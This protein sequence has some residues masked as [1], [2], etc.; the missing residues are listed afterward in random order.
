MK[1][2]ILAI[3]ISCVVFSA[4]PA[5][6]VSSD[7][8][9]SA[10]LMHADT[11]EVLY[12]KNISEQMLIASTTK[13]VTAIVVLKNVSPD[14]VVEILPEYTGIEGSSMYLAAGQ[15]YTVYEL[16]QGLLLVSGNDAATA[17]AYYVGGSIE[18][19]ADMMNAYAKSLGLENTQFKNPHGLDAEGHYSTAYD[20][21]IITAQAMQ[22]ETF[23]EISSTKSADIG[24][25]TFVNHNKLLWLCDGC[26]GG[27]TGYTIAAGRSLVSF[28]E[29]DGMRLICVT[30]SDPDDWNT[31]VALYNWGYDNYKYESIS[32]PSE[33]KL[34]VIS[35][36]KEQVS[37]S[38]AE[39]INVLLP[40]TAAYCCS[41]ELPL[42]AYAPVIK[43]EV[44]GTLSVS[45]NG[46]VVGSADIITQESAELDNEIKLTL[47]E[48]VKLSWY[49]INTIPVFNKYMEDG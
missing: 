49:R 41:I 2:T 46:E 20:L 13:I 48:R 35:G 33:Q 16:L 6:A 5:Y 22:N 34:M 4:I 38:I 37:V 28:T 26:F 40:K 10:I 11:G 44:V 15:S 36:L 8:A 14:E 19:F 21:A 47:W 25:L 45:Y 32:L 1:K 29:R 24:E 3:L 23:C 17:L 27:K 18:G 42:F 43:D 31:H 12:E 30:I 39:N 9:Q 7:T